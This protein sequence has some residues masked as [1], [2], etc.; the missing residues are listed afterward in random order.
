ERAERARMAQEL[1][2]AA[3]IQTGILPRDSKVAGLE[4]ASSMLP[5]DEVGGDYFDILPIDNGCWLTIGDVAGH[6]LK[7]GLVMLMIQSIFAATT[8]VRPTARPAMVWR[9]LNHVL[10]E[11]VRQRLSQDEHATLTLLRYDVDGRVVYAGAHE[12]MV[13]Y[14]A[15]TQ[16]AEVIPT[17]GI[18]AGITQQ[19][20]PD[21]TPE[22]ELQLE[23]GDVLVLYTD[24]VVEAMDRDQEP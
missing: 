6:G 13:V 10:C 5:A 17:P 15:R 24:G 18:W 1:E 4:I 23:V 11:N 12:D 9:A 8:H 14:R 16:K 20:P 22:G 7:T 3:S 19:L 21:A 2:I